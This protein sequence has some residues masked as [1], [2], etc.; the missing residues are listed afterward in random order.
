MSIINQ[1]NVTLYSNNEPM[2]ATVFNRPLQ[3]IINEVNAYVPPES[4]ST[5]SAGDGL[6][7]TGTTF[8]VNGT[9]VRT[10]GN[11]TVNGAFTFSQIVTGAGFNST[12]DIRLKDRVEEV[13][14]TL[15]NT[16]SIKLCEWI[17]RDHECVPEHLRG[18]YDSGVIAD[19]VL[20]VFPSC[21][22]VND[23]GYKTVDY[24][25]LAVHLILSRKE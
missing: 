11:F 2:S 7:L 6:S 12:S 4:G 5:Y 16:D 3:Q 19:E 15:Y 17:W 24:G 23:F 9:V 22:S 18:V 20:K 1:N 14:A 13:D 8:A 25:K 21:V 10:T